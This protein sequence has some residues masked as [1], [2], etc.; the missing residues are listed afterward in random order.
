MFYA[1][2]TANTGQDKTF[3][4]AAN[5][6]P[7]F[8]WE[9]NFGCHSHTAGYI[10]ITLSQKRVVPIGFSSQTE[11]GLNSLLGYALCRVIHF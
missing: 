3:A 5:H 2:T 7:V 8:F 4:V 6:A 9:A 11:K 1:D 10:H